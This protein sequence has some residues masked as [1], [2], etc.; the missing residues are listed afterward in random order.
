MVGL[1]ERVYKLPMTAM[2]AILTKY[3]SVVMKWVYLPGKLH[4]I[5]F[6]V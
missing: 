5:S 1:T 4:Q 2:T 6:P 3:C